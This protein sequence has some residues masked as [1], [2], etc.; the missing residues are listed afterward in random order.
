MGAFSISENK[1]IRKLLSSQYNKINSLEQKIKQL[2]DT[3]QELY[4]LKEKVDVAIH[5]KND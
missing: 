2:E 3:I 1:L 4:A 5:L